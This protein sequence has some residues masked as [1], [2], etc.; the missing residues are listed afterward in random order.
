VEVDGD[1][2][3]VGESDAFADPPPHALATTATAVRGSRRRRN[4][5]VAR[6]R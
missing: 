1:D 3:E 5:R 6:V 2:E 4:G